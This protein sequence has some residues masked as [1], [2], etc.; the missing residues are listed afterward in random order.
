LIL[1]INSLI[2]AFLA[3]GSSSRPIISENASIARQ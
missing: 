3:T 2:K 1:W